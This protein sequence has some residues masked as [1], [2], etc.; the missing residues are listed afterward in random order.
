MLKSILTSRL[1]LII[2]LLALD[3]AFFSLTDP[4][5]VDSI[6]LVIGFLL[7]TST[8]YLCIKQLLAAAKLY[9]LPFGNRERRV[10]IFITGLAGV[11]IAL[12]SIGELTRRDLLVVGPLAVILYVYVSY[13]RAGAVPK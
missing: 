3:S 2:S 8:F 5:K 7:V 13:G 4:S 10:A 1:W 12:Q 6:M 11:L 9:G